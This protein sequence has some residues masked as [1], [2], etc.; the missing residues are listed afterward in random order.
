MDNTSDLSP[1]V[2]KSKARTTME[3]SYINEFL[4][5]AETNNFF[6]AADRLSVSESTLSRHIKAL[7]EELGCS[8]FDR[9][10]RTM[11][12]SSGGAIFLPYAE[13]F[14]ALKQRC[15]NELNE[16]EKKEKHTIVV[17]SSYFIDDVIANFLHTN[18]DIIVD[19]IDSHGDLEDLKN[20]LRRNECSLA[21]AI[22]LQDP[23]QT[24][25]SSRF[26][27]DCYVA[28]LPS[29]HRLAHRDSI[30]LSELSEDP[31]VSF[32]ANSRSDLTM[33]KLC[34]VAGF[35]PKIS[36]SADVGSSIVP[37]IKKGFGVSIL[38]KKTI[39][40]MGVDFSGVKIV[41]LDPKPEFTVSIIYLKTAKLTPA[42]R[43]FY[44]F[45]INK[46]R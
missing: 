30:S 22:D 20:K 34:R 13:Q 38:Q 15:T 44:D 36:M 4:V 41:D 35:A 7:E 28:I 21:F 8:L 24:L 11:K 32:R 12:I 43:C 33:K 23:D 26:D 5:L 29:N 17:A 39:Y 10:T 3:L 14:I 25:V 2:S 9:T 37:L 31:F 1:P 18:E 19:V 16:A 27:T 40:K 45:C 6:D 46:F 42:E